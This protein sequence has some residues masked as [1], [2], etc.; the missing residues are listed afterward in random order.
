MQFDQIYDNLKICLFAVLNLS[1]EQEFLVNVTQ[2]F[3]KVLLEFALDEE[4]KEIGAIACKIICNLERSSNLTVQILIYKAQLG[5]AGLEAHKISVNNE[6]NSEPDKVL[7]FGKKIGEDRGHNE[8]R[9]KTQKYL[10][11]SICPEW[12]LQ[13]YPNADRNSSVRGESVASP[14]QKS[15]D[16]NGTIMTINEKNSLTKDD[17]SLT[18]FTKVSCLVSPPTHIPYSTF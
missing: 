12:F 8:N 3:L 17:A 6:I 14:H 7:T 13:D 11:G 16:D 15:L 4:D 18:S 5:L 1:V 10:K 2:K 9:R